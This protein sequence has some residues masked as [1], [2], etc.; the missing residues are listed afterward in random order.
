MNGE[1]LPLQPHENSLS[2]AIAPNGRSF[3]LGTHWRLI[4]F[5]DQGR[6]LWNIRRPTSVSAVNI[7]IDGRIAVTAEDDGAIHWYRME[8]GQELLS[9]FAR[10]DSG[11]WVAWT[12]SGYYMASVDGDSLVGWHVNQGADHTADFFSVARFRNHY[13]RPDVI[14]RLFQTL[15][16]GEAVQRADAAAGRHEATRDIAQILPP[17]VTIISPADGVVTMDTR[18]KLEFELRSPSGEPVT[19]VQIRV[20][21][22]PVGGIEGVLDVGRDGSTYSLSALVPPR[23]A[24]IEVIAENRFG[25]A[26]DPANV[27]VVWDGPAA[28]RKPKLYVLAV[29]ISSY[30]DPR[31]ALDLASKDARDFVD[32]LLTQRGR[33][34]DEVEVSLLT[35]GA[36]DLQRLEQALDWIVTAPGRD[37][38]AMVFLAGHG[39]DDAAGR[40]FFMP[41]DADPRELDSTSLSYERLKGA[42]SRIAGRVYFFVDTCKSGAIWGRPGE[43]S[44]DVN[45]LVND[46]KSPEHGVVVF[47]SL[48]T[49]P[50]M[51]A[52]I[53]A[54]VR[55]T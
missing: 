20:D 43:P 44:T 18:V 15:D 7:T 19:N 38:V 21:G 10:K 25:V 35:D 11:R 42:L 16:E 27:R 53:A 32:T 13:Y 8:D 37:D 50:A 40:Y 55:A 2:L 24:V 47:A 6:E 49:Q 1:P 9:F 52:P 31:L 17:V 5:D 4:R 23:D 54:P 28:E 29:G 36:A 46:L 22:R 41:F 3:L 30:S 34:Y 26:S 48:Y 51:W 14:E 45:R 39:V 33:A 12:P